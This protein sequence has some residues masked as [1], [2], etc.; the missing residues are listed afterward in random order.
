MS[1][2]LSIVTKAVAQTTVIFFT[3]LLF[4]FKI[5]TS[6]VGSSSI[7]PPHIKAMVIRLS[8]TVNILKQSRI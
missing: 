5:F 3:A 2:A 8:F 1:V 6:R 7:T 4:T